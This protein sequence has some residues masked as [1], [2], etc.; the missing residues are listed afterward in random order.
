[1]PEHS[2]SVGKEGLGYFG[3]SPLWRDLPRCPVLGPQAQTCLLLV[4]FYFPL[5][6]LL[7]SSL[8]PSCHQCPMGPLPPAFPVAPNPHT[9]SFSGVVGLPMSPV[10]GYTTPAGLPGA[11]APT[12]QPLWSPYQLP[13]LATPVL[14]LGIVTGTPEESCRGSCH[15][16]YPSHW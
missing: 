9:C 10:V 3:C 8:L 14:V 6:H 11:Q 4:P 15:K 2:P 16:C 12:P 7:L 5:W 13:T 1:M